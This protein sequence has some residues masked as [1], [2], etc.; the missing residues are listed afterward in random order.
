MRQSSLQGKIF[1]EGAMPWR[2]VG[3]GKRAQPAWLN[4]LSCSSYSWLGCPD[5]L[6]RTRAERG[7]HL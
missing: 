5:R 3:S 2:Q 1:L 4:C 7:D 6:G